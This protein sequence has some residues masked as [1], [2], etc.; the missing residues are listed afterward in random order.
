[1]RDLVELDAIM[2]RVFADEDR[3]REWL[4]RSNMNLG[5]RTPLEMM[6]R[7]PQWVRWLIDALAVVS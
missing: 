5:N 4:R 7:S 1:M 2:C 6:T 3:I